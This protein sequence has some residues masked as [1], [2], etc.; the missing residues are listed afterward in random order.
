MAHKGRL[1]SCGTALAFHP[2]RPSLLAV[3]MLNG[4]VVVV[5]TAAAPG[6]A[7]LLAT[8]PFDDSH[9]EPITAVCLLGGL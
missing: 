1:Q 8:S 4:D 7:F 9:E 5:N 2:A 3:G 6:E